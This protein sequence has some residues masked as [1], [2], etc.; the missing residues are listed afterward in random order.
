MKAHPYTIVEGRPVTIWIILVLI[1][2]GAAALLVWL[3]PL[4][5]SAGD[6]L[7]DYLVSPSEE[8]T[9]AAS[10]WNSIEAL[11]PVVKGSPLLA[12]LYVVYKL[13]DMW[14]WKISL[15]S[16]VPN[17][18]GKWRGHL[19]SDEMP[20]KPL[21]VR[22]RIRQTWSKIMIEVDSIPTFSHSVTASVDFK[23]SAKL[24]II[25]TYVAEPKPNIHPAVIN[26]HYGTNIIHLE[27]A[28]GKISEIGGIYYTERNLG[29]HGSFN[30]RIQ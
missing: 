27:F 7:W 13:F 15:F 18:N 12:C 2:F 9:D 16:K 8:E 11:A 10:I 22:L 4:L 5:V 28:D 25:N 17:L 26:R 19:V 14:M 1:S 6:G 21:E 30:F 3:V 23:G 20:D 24:E 29:H